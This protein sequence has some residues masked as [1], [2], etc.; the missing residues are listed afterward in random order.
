MATGLHIPPTFVCHAY[1][2]LRSLCCSS[3]RA[4]AATSADS[5]W[6]PGAA[7]VEASGV[8]ACSAQDLVAW[9]EGR[10]LEELL[11][12]AKSGGYN[13]E[14]GAPPLPASPPCGEPPSPTL[15]HPTK[16]EPSAD[17]PAAALSPGAVCLSNLDSAAAGRR[18]PASSSAVTEAPSESGRA[19]EDTESCPTSPAGVWSTREA[20]AAAALTNKAAEDARPPVVQWTPGDW[21]ERLLDDISDIW[22]GAV[23]IAAHGGDIYDVEYADDN[24]VERGVEG[25]ELRARKT[26]LDLPAEVWECVGGCLLGKADLCTFETVARAACAATKREGQRWWCVTYH[27]RFGRCGPRCLFRRSDGKTNMKVS[28][29]TVAECF[30]TASLGQTVVDRT[31]WKERYKEQERLHAASLEYDRVESGPGDAAYSVSGKRVGDARSRYA[32]DTTVGWY[33]DPRLGRMV[34]ES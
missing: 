34:K 22:T 28:R 33:F 23:V 14:C 1:A 10:A 17:T 30:D 8:S 11:S 21:V 32:D 13:P 4:V 5:T 29:E 15:Q 9:A 12:H 26:R 6:D 27:D 2:Q 16:C 20:E 24:S 7:S 25:S 19:T 18:S 31:P 3:A